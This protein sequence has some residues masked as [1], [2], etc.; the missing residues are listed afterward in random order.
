MVIFLP[1]LYKETSSYRVKQMIAPIKCEHFCN[2]AFENTVYFLFWAY[3]QLCLR[4][5][6]GFVFRAHSWWAREI[7][8][9][10]RL[11]VCKSNLSI[12]NILRKITHVSF[13]F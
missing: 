10:A 9:D 2:L 7:I 13:S 12:L 11:A 4:L 3:V 1:D 8:W 6:P 5:T